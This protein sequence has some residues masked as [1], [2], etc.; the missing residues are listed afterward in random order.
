MISSAPAPAPA[1]AGLDVFSGSG[2]G[3]EAESPKPGAAA[4]AAAYCLWLPGCKGGRGLPGGLLRHSPP[5]LS[6]GPLRAKIE[7]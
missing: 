7:S 5:P 3:S 1:L 4:A 6:A 2:L